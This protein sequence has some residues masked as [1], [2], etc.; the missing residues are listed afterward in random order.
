[1][2]KTIYLDNNGTTYTCKIARQAQELWSMEPYNPSSN[3]KFGVKAKAM[4]EDA[5]KKFSVALNAP[6]KNYMVLFTSGGSESNSMVMSAIIESRKN[7]HIIISEIEHK[8]ILETCKRLNKK[9][10]V[11]FSLVKPNENG[12][13]TADAVKSHIKKNTCLISVMFANNET[14]VIND[15][16]EIGELAGKRNIPF[17]CDAVQAFGKVPINMKGL[18][19][20]FL[21]ASSHKIYGPKGVGLLVL[22]RD[23]V[24]KY[25][26]CGQISGSQQETL[27]GG[28]ENPGGIAGF[29]A[30]YSYVA[31]NR[32]NKNI[33]LKS[34]LNEF[35]TNLKYPIVFYCDRHKI[36][37]PN[38]PHLVI[39]G[40]KKQRMPNT[41]LVAI[42]FNGYCNL[43][44]K[45][46]LETRNIIVSIGSACNTASRAKASHVILAMG[47]EKKYRN[48]IRISIGDVNTK[49]EIKELAKQINTFINATS[50]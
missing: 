23:M 2:S 45:G 27:R 14:G 7:P 35:I 34:V 17:H 33:Y 28:T 30:A 29:L 50:K 16:K 15:I 21:S 43:R 40:D 49:G 19:I 1:M 44:L 47:I 10:G 37:D 48:V 18:N 22:Q 3:N 8:G 12:I 5:K 36:K 41:L 31:S 11:D 9:C 46:Y 13:I 26:M 32:Q 20:N 42:S 25:K 4:I 6:C 38:Q 39:I 24:N